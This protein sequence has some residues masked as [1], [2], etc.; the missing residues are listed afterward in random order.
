MVALSVGRYGG[1]DGRCAQLRRATT[2]VFVIGLHLAL[3]LLLT[4]APPVRRL[5]KEG[6]PF[7]VKLLPL[8]STEE[9]ALTTPSA[10][11]PPNSRPVPTPPAEPIKPAPPVSA[12]P[13]P[14]V[15]PLPT[16]PPA[17][18]PPAAVTAREGDI[19][20]AGGRGRAAAVGFAPARWVRKI[21]DE[22]FFPL[23]PEDL[24]RVP[25]DVT[26]RLRCLVAAD[27]R[28]DCRILSESPTIPGV[29]T[30]VLKGLP[31]LRMRPPMRD[32]RPLLDQPV[33]FEWRVG[34]HSRFSPLDR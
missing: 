13:Q 12:T 34:Q 29:R 31:M 10:P 7:I 6:T 20:M 25:M 3:L 32:G 15:L 26:F 19:M 18:M 9:P 27:T 23:M 22:E 33:E 17:P 2:L 4:L 30:A 5:V 8:P 28:I 21:T 11:Q 14:S 1:D 16:P 24:W